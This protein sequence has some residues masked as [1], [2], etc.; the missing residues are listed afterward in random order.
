MSENSALLNMK[1]WDTES[2]SK[3]YLNVWSR[4]SL[5]ERKSVL[6]NRFLHKV[7]DSLVLSDDI[8]DLVNTKGFLY[9]SHGTQTRIQLY[10]NGT[11]IGQVKRLH[12]HVRKKLVVPKALGGHL[13]MASERTLDF[14]YFSAYWITTKNY[15][16]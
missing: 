8:T 12:Y 1:Y 15:S 14:S 5:Y 16:A 6:S 11:I 2:I 3:E 13:T 10:S 4:Q 9:R 7:F